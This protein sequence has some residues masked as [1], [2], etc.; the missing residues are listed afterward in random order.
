MCVIYAATIICRFQLLNQASLNPW[1]KP[2]LRGLTSYIPTSTSPSLSALDSSPVDSSR[3]TSLSHI[4][5][6][7]IDPA[8]LNLSTRNLVPRQNWIEVLARAPPEWIMYEAT[9][10]NLRDSEWDECF[11]RRFLPGWKKRKGDGRWRAA[12]IS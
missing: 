6:P 7:N 3:T 12:F 1:R 10:P 11:R 4:T 9:L 2:M 8:L 5:Y